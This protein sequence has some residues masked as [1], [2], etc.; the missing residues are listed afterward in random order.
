MKTNIIWIF[1]ILLLFLGIQTVS[2]QTSYNVDGHHLFVQNGNYF[3]VFNSDTMPLTTNR[4]LVKL[5]DNI[6]DDEKSIFTSN[7]P[8][9]PV[10][11]TEF[12]ITLYNVNLNTD[13]IQLI[14]DLSIDNSV[15]FFDMN[16]LIGY[17]AMPFPP[18][19]DSESI[20]TGLLEQDPLHLWPYEYTKL[21]DAWQI[22]KGNSDIIVAML[23]NGIYTDHPDIN[24]GGDSYSNLWIN[25]NEIPGNGIDD[26]NNEFVDDVYGW[27]ISEGIWWPGGSDV[28]H[29]NPFFPHGT[30]TSSI[31]ASKTNNEIGTFGVAGGW[32][33]QGIK[34][35]TVCIGF[36]INEVTLPFAIEYAVKNGAQIINM[37]W[38]GTGGWYSN[39]LESTIWDYYNTG[40]VVFLASVGN[41]N[42]NDE[43]GFPARLET[44]L[45][46]GST[47][48]QDY[49]P[50]EYRWE[51]DNG[52][53]GYGSNY[54]DD[55]E[56]SAPGC[57]LKTSSI[58]DEY[59]NP[60][61]TYQYSTDESQG[62]TSFSAPFASGIVGL[63][64]SVDPC[65]TNDEIREILRNTADKVNAGQPPYQYDYFH[66]PSRPG[67]S[68]QLGYGRINA[69]SALKVCI[70]FPE[71]TISTNTTW[72]AYMRIDG[73]VTIED[74]AELT[75]GSDALIK[76]HPYNK[77]IVKP[78]GRL[79]VDGGTITTSCNY[80]WEGIEVHGNPELPQIPTSNQGYVL[81]KNNGKIENAI[82]AI[83]VYRP[84][85]HKMSPLTPPSEPKSGGIAMCQDA[86]FI[87]NRMAV[88]IRYL[89]NIKNLSSFNKCRFEINP[90]YMVKKKDDNGNLTSPEYNQMVN[91]AFVSGIDFNA[92]TFIVKGYDYW[93]F[94]YF[95]KAINSTNSNFRLK[96]M[97]TQVPCES[98]PELTNT[99]QGF[100]YGIYAV[101]NG[102][103]Q[104]FRVEQAIFTNNYSC[105]YA[106]SIPYAKILKNK[107]SIEL[108]LNLPEAENRLASGL[109]LNECTGY[110]IEGNEF[111]GSSENITTHNIGAYIKNSGEATNYVYNNKFEKLTYGSIAEGYNCNDD[112]T[113]RGTGLCYKCNDFSQTRFDIFVANPW[114]TKAVPYGIRAYQGFRSLS[115]TAA[116]GNVFSQG[117][118]WMNVL[119]EGKYEIQYFHHEQ[120]IGVAPEWL[121]PVRREYVS[122][123]KNN[124]TTYSKSSSC[125]S[126]I[127]KP[128]PPPERLMADYSE[129][130]LIETASKEAI[131]QLK[132]GGNTETVLET[133]EN[134]YP[135]EAFVLRDDLLSK[136]PYLSDTTLK[137]AIEKEDVL[138]NALLRDV[139]TSNPQAGK[140]EALL[141]K[142]DEKSEPMPD[143]MY[144]EIL[145]SAENP[146]PYN[147]LLEDYAEANHDRSLAFNNLVETFIADTLVENSQQ[148][149]ENLVNI[150]Q[151]VQAE[152]VLIKYYLDKGLFQNATSRMLQLQIN[153]PEIMD[154]ASIQG[155][156]NEYLNIYIPAITDTLFVLDTTSKQLLEELSVQ[157]EYPID[158]WSENLLEVLTTNYQPETYILPSNFENKKVRVRPVAAKKSDN[159]KLYVYPN[160]A[161]THFVAR[162]SI[163]AGTKKA[164]LK[165]A[166]IDGRLVQEY[167]LTDFDNERVIRIN[168][169][170][171]AVY[172]TE[173]FADGKRISN[174]KLTIVH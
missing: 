7:Y 37:S 151:T 153:L 162:Y 33:C 6:T 50:N 121:I 34:V 102:T 54:G 62:W 130:K 82:C 68:R 152:L 52:Q 32:N 84:D 113:I 165:I 23:D 66:D 105:I 45:A 21:V 144:L 22:S 104:N 2:S 9:I 172:I 138:T 108:S 107:F 171:E 30:W 99:F 40:K 80:F 61:V 71:Q 91:L 147:L 98:E 124:G 75:I 76:F 122:P 140:S 5:K 133:I 35:M 125:K 118:N 106:N 159:H 8:L 24:Y 97:C 141:I 100:N 41:N 87:N 12:G 154:I 132:D 156:L 139:L 163:P 112:G 164:T 101:N 137:S 161:S 127:G 44:V 51:Y 28:S 43:I 93:D 92:C 103:L 20:I 96:P 149:L 64:L 10:K 88:D 59:G 13:F 79:I 4:I 25:E 15:E 42:Y 89:P 174:T 57:A 69:D 14:S 86:I 72:N 78:G 53:Y 169:L 38:G 129:S 117:E 143:E 83:R 157:G 136:S 148:Q 1:S 77:I 110:H 109:Y 134:S 145:E 115:D 55:T 18:T 70:P 155:Q 60:S 73:N 120:S 128:I 85:D 146:S 48:K 166:T 11:T 90:D 74:G 63:M 95:G 39:S 158:T 116:A 135:D 123:H 26:D 119:N 94:N 46:V 3:E 160:P 67:H 142:L 29:S 111:I 27:N 36:P 150:D 170:T 47:M 58:V 81:V 167:T 19:N 56:I 168:E 173:L 16:H 65:L 114:A 49:G 31:V 17:H 131:I 126:W